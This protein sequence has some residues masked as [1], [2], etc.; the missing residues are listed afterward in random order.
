MEVRVRY[1]GRDIAEYFGTSEKFEVLQIPEGS[2]YGQL[3][4]RFRER[5]VQALR[6]RH[7]GKIN[8]DMLSVFVFVSGGRN[9]RRIP[10]EP[11]KD[12]DE[13]LVVPA[14]AGG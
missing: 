4:E 2:T 7:G 6:R 13:I 1:V 12:G 14:D 9:I 10:D 8:E 5:F 11:V 3:L